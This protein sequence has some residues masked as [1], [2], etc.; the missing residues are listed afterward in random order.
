MKISCINVQHIS[1]NLVLRW[2]SLRISWSEVAVLLSYS[3]WNF[4]SFWQIWKYCKSKKA[5]SIVGEFILAL[6]RLDLVLKQVSFHKMLGG[7][8]LGSVAQPVWLFQL[9]NSISFM[10]LFRPALWCFSFQ[11]D[12]QIHLAPAPLIEF[13][14]LSSVAVKTKNKQ[15]LLCLS[16]LSAD[17]AKSATFSLWRR[18]NCCFEKAWL[19][20]ESCFCEGWARRRIH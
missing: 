17:S 13:S 5:G 20:A 1:C 12:V 19:E 14:S 10:L 8:T 15:Y 2:I 11:T 4:E 7:D 9:E 18:G 16:S 6:F 3:E